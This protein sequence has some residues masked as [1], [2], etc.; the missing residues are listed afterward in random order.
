MGG[1]APS[2][3]R[4]RTVA[5]V[6]QKFMRNLMESDSF[7]LIPSLSVR[8]AI[9]ITLQHCLCFRELTHFFSYFVKSSAGGKR[10]GDRGR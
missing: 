9:V 7:R 4:V 6:E 3:F 2:H 1:V 5:Q 8:A 10:T